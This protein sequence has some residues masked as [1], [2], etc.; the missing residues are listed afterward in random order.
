MKPRVRPAFP[1]PVLA[2]LCI[3]SA[4]GCSRPAPQAAAVPA[5]AAA[6]DVLPRNATPAAPR[7]PGPYESAR[8]S[9]AREATPLPD[10]SGGTSGE[11]LPK[12]GRQVLRCTDKGRVTYVDLNTRCLE[13]PGE[14]VTVFPTEGVEKPR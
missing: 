2:A 3:V 5:S 9:A 1:W 11:P 8:P 10:L 7:E 12:A 13:G 6:P 14:R 4:A